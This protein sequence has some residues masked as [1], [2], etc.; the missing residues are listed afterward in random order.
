[1]K[2]L[3]GAAAFAERRIG[4]WLARDVEAVLRFTLEADQAAIAID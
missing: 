3:A 4:R 1:M 2:Q